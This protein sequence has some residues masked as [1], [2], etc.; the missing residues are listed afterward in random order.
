[1]WDSYFMTKV[2]SNL[3]GKV[4]R[5]FLGRLDPDFLDL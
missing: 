3:T 4:E 2:C 5:K 1:M